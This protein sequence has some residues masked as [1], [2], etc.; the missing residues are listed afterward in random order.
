MADRAKVPLISGALFLLYP[1]AVFIGL[2]YLDPRWLALLLIIAAGWRLIRAGGLGTGFGPAPLMA[3]AVCATVITLV[4]GSSHG[5]LLY[6]VLVNG[7]LLVL[8]ATSLA[9][10][11]SVIET[12]ARLREPDLPPQAVRYTRQVTQVWTLFFAVNGT[13][14]LITVFLDRQWW[15]LYN[16][17]IAYLLMGALM[18]SEWL[19]RRRVRGSIH[20]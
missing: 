2:R 15:V 18:G 4:T 13:I 5:L 12:L 1:V 6:P 14:A 7:V 11:P 16:G 20:G 19:I 8:F 9:R 17:L 10:P 3:A